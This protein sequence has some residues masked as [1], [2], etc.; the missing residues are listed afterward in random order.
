MK[1]YAVAAAYEG[2]YAVFSTVELAQAFIAEHPG[3]D[4]YIGEI[5]VDNPLHWV[6]K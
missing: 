5:E 4:Y 6:I 2:I 1:L 3:A